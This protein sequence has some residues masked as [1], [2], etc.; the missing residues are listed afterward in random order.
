MSSDLEILAAP[1]LA[2]AAVLAV[3]GATKLRNPAPASVA[4]RSVGLGGSTTT[5]RALGAIELVVGVAALVAPV[6]ATALL[7]AVAYAGLAA[8]AVLVLRTRP[9]ADCGCF[10]ATS[11]PVGVA[12]VALDAAAALVAL[13][14]AVDPLGSTADLLADQPVAGVPFVVLTGLLAWLVVVTMTDLTALLRTVRT[15]GGAG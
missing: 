13:G 1:F 8:F 5:A 12:H 2:A 11:A 3:S 6:R 7:L 4:M 14:V 15:R 10:G 9:G